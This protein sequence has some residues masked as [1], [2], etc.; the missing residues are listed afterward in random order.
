MMTRTDRR[1]FPVLFAAIAVLAVAGAALGLLFS[2]A[3]AQEAETLVSNIGQ[4]N[5]TTREFSVPYAQRFTTGPYEYGYTLSTVDVVSADAEGTSFEAKVC[6]VDG[7]GH[8]T[9]TCTDL[10]APG[11]SGFAAGTITFYAPANYVL[12]AETTYTVVLTPPSQGSPIVTYGLTT[13]DGEDAGKADGWSIADMFDYKFLGDPWETSPS[14]RKFRIAIKGSQAPEPETTENQ[15]GEIRA[16][17]NVPGHFGG[18]SMVGCAGTVPFRAFWERPKRADEWEAEVKPEYGASNLSLSSIEYIG[19]GFHELTGTVHVRDGEFGVVSIRV[20]GRFGDDGWGAW[21]RPTELFCLPTPPPRTLADGVKV[22]SS[23]ASGDTYGP[24]ETIE[25]TVE[26]SSAVV[27]VGDP[28]F[29]F[30]MGDDECRTGT[31]PPAR[32]RAAYSSG[33]GTTELVFSYVVGSDDDPDDDGNGIWIGDGTRTLQLDS[34]DRIR[35]AETD[36]NAEIE[37]NA[38]GDQSDHKVNALA[39]IDEIAVT[40]S[41]ASGDTYD[42]GETIEITVT[43]DLAVNVTGDPQFGIS[44]GGQKLASFTGG[45]GTT[46][47]VF[48]YT[49][50]FGDEDDN[51]IWIGSHDHDSNPTFRL[52]SDDAITG[53]VTGHDADLAH[54]VI[55]QQNGH[56]VDGATAPQGEA[57]HSEPQE[58]DEITALTAA[59]ADLPSS[60]EGTAFTFRIE[61]SEDVAV[62][63]AEMRDHALTVTGGTVTGAAQVD[64]RADRW[65]ITVTPSGTEEVLISLPPG[66]DCSEA[67]AVC[68]ADGRQLPTGLAQIVAGPPVE[69][70]TASFEGMPAEH[71]GERAFTFRIAFSE[72]LSWMNGRRLREDVVAVAGG[73]ATSAS[74]VDRRRDLWQLT[75]EPDSP[76]DVTVTLAAGAAC[77]TPAAVCTKDGQALSE[78]ISA[79]VAGP[80]AS[81]PDQP[82]GLEATAS[83]DSVTLTWDDPGDDSITGYVILRRIRVNDTGGDFDVLVADT[84]TAATT[85]TDD[86]VAAST[87]YTYRIKAINGAGTSERSRWFHIDTPA[88]PASK[89]AVADGPPGLVPNA[90]N[91]FNASTLIP[92]RLAAPGPVRLEI[93]NLLGQPVRTLVD[94]YQDAGFYKVRWDARDRR[95]ALVSAGMY[96]VR[97]HYPGGVQTQRL[98]YLK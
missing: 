80:P 33:S 74:R 88:A 49:V 25:I 30:C 3:E 27:V 77:G 57:G 62:S 9:S 51:G 23:P 52:D 5:T 61:F 50:Q 26:F 1:R 48:G 16:Y 67:G 90:P 98:L 34:D 40:S 54:D 10:A 69:P 58:D 37:H 94:Q 70:L 22:T 91:P 87:T 28:E 81:A 96:L 44:A 68:T 20:R 17:W 73:R 45:S 93:Y 2:T 76:A 41:P 12:E 56:K 13:A 79:T 83:H 85:Y 36:D 47:L 59:F 42:T 53:A 64:G 7:D 18:N 43:F 89:P 65:S 46:E 75:V 32:R 15:P 14:N 71:D 60:H 55:G 86:T 11:S 19:D 8:P 84:G 35:S 38:L 63:A 72:P 4:G 92:Y 24:G 78:T 6:T 39:D 82:T 95:G 31:D 97:L 66:R 29:E 21:S